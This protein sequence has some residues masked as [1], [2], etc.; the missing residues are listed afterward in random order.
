MWWEAVKGQEG[1]NKLSEQQTTD[2]NIIGDSIQGTYTLSHLEQ[3]H[4]EL[5]GPEMNRFRD[6]PAL[7]TQ[8]RASVY[9]RRLREVDVV[10]VVGCCMWVRLRARL[11]NRVEHRDTGSISNPLLFYRANRWMKLPN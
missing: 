8:R 6:D 5:G 2:N 7:E 3:H 10:T 1:G 4:P 9:V 11:D